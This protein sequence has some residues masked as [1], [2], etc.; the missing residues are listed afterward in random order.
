MQVL[1]F[2]HTIAIPVEGGYIRDVPTVSARACVA[3]S[4]EVP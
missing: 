4:A 3:C 1:D 2:D